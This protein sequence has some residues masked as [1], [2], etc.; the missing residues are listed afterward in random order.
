MGSPQPKPWHRTEIHPLLRAIKQCCICISLYDVNASDWT[1]KHSQ[2]LDGQIV[3]LVE[4][5][6]IEPPTSA[7]RLQRSPS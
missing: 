2:V 3:I 1:V 5:S 7:V 6:G 4:P